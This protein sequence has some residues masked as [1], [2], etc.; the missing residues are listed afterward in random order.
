MNRSFKKDQNTP[1]HYM[2]LVTYFHKED[3]VRLLILLGL[4]KITSDLTIL[5]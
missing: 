5:F 1:I 3:I 4:E 2:E